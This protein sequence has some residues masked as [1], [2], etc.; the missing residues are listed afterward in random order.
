[1]ASAG[2]A[3]ITFAINSPLRRSAGS[4]ARALS[5]VS[6]GKLPRVISSSTPSGQPLSRDMHSS[7]GMLMG[8]YCKCCGMVG[9]E[10][11]ECTNVPKV[12]SSTAQSA[13]AIAAWPDR[14]PAAR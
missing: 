12:R 10:A 3:A 1:M 4:T 13:L 14:R 9:H 2:R 5:S 7:N 8:Q 11:S 6:S